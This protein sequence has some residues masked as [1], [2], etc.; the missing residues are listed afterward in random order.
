MVYILDARWT[1]KWSKFKNRKYR[2][3]YRSKPTRRNWTNV[4]FEKIKRASSRNKRRISGWR[5]KQKSNFYCFCN[6]QWDFIRRQRPRQGWFSADFYIFL[7]RVGLYRTLLKTLKRNKR[8]RIWQCESFDKF[9]ILIWK[10]VNPLKKLSNQ[11]SLRQMAFSL[12][13]YL[14]PLMINFINFVSSNQGQ[15]SIQSYR[16]LIG[17]LYKPMRARNPHRIRNNHENF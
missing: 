17:S 5:N 14:M 16:S 10:L 9:I 12:I 13:K 2:R 4:L 3:K 7:R 11:K 6:S 8:K 1:S 15:F